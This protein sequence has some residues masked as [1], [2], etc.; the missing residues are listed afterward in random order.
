MLT[1]RLCRYAITAA[2]DEW[3]DAAAKVAAQASSGGKTTLSVANPNS[4]K[5]RGPTTEREPETKQKK[6]KAQ[7]G[8]RKG[9]EHKSGK[10]A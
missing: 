4:T 5:K 2:P 8:G 10:R 7:H 1:R 9:S 3:A 6:K